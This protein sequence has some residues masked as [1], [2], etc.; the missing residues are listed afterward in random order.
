MDLRG[1]GLRS[2][3]LVSRERRKIYGLNPTLKAAAGISRRSLG[4]QSQ[5]H[6]GK[7]SFSRSPARLTAASISHAASGMLFHPQR[8]VLSRARARRANWKWKGTPGGCRGGGPPSVPP[9]AARTPA[10]IGLTRLPPRASRTGEGERRVKN[11]RPALGVAVPALVFLHCNTHARMTPP[12]A[13]RLLLF[14]TATVSALRFC[15]SSHPATMLSAAPFLERREE[16]RVER[17]SGAHR[18]ARRP[19]WA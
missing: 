9:S 19:R 11:L 2:D 7:L 17:R 1:K 15:A 14:A 3:L 5:R 13:R 12:L 10:C 18:R 8:R 6:L 4:R 16:S